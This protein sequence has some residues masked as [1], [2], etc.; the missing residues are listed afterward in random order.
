MKMDDK[1]FKLL[2]GVHYLGSTSKQSQSFIDYFASSTK[3]ST[4][5]RCVQTQTSTQ[6]CT[7]NDYSIQSPQITKVLI[8][9]SSFQ[10]V[11][12]TADSTQNTYEDDFY[13]HEN[14]KI[15]ESIQ[16]PITFTNRNSGIPNQK[17]FY[18]IN[19]LYIQEFKEKEYNYKTRALILNRILDNCIN[20][21]NPYF[22]KAIYLFDLF[23][24]KLKCKTISNQQQLRFLSLAIIFVI[25]KM[26]A[27]S[28]N[29][30]LLLSQSSLNMNKQ[31]LLQYERLIL[32][33][34]DWHT[35][36]LTLQDIFYEVIL[37]FQ[38]AFPNLNAYMSNEKLN[39]KIQINESDMKVINQILNVIVLDHN[40]LSHDFDDLSFSILYVM[41][42][43]ELKEN[44]FEDF[45]KNHEKSKSQILTSIKFV[46][47]FIRVV[48]QLNE[49]QLDINSLEILKLVCD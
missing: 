6:D 40:Y 22:H 8:L 32:K 9:T 14:L 29:V 36:P 5:K 38:V 10:K 16:L 47:K 12:T 4:I 49:K 48:Q 46:S 18:Y 2:L 15:E 7:Q 21:N 11:K 44:E 3:A 20:M 35:N 24:S 33:V 19:P 17:Q 25:T 42:Q 1:R 30:N 31:Q 26:N 41:Y 23:L 13:C 43:K 45:L 34:L 39:L 28:S 27:E 37:R